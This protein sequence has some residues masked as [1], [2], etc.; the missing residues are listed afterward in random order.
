MTK[1]YLLV[2]SPTCS[3][4]TTFVN[5]M[6][7]TWPGLIDFI[8]MDTVLVCKR[9]LHDARMAA[10]RRQPLKRWWNHEDLASDTATRLEKKFFA[11]LERATFPTGA[12]IT[13][14]LISE[15]VLSR[16]DAIVLPK[17]DEYLRRIASRVEGKV[18]RDQV[19]VTVMSL[20]CW[21]RVY[22]FGLCS[23][24]LMFS[25]FDKLI[26]WIPLANVELMG[27]RNA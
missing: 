20:K 25:D 12:V 24:T 15:R 8:D 1:N 9:V 22:N 7:Q 21:N 18:V 5:Q 27:G 26:E 6:T 16:A 17:Y 3:G 10:A 11:W 13:T 19:D 4:K 2:A 14:S 23:S